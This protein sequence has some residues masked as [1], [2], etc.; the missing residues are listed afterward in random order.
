MQAQRRQMRPSKAN[1]IILTKNAIAPNLKHITKCMEFLSG[2]SDHDSF[3]NINKAN[4]WHE[5]KRKSVSLK[6][7]EEKQLELKTK[8]EELKQTENDL[9]EKEQCLN[10]KELDLKNRRKTMDIEQMR[11]KRNLQ[12]LA[13]DQ[14]LFERQKQ[15]QM[16]LI[17]LTAKK[18]TAYA[19]QLK[20]REKELLNR[21][22]SLLQREHA[23]YQR[24]KDVLHKEHKAKLM[25]KIC[26]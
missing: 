21:E 23:L 24:E 11:Y 5:N 1:E 16:A 12:Q 18:N 3:D 26:K 19:V 22:K 20:Q 13:D 2:Y 4:A 6:A 7:I 10:D 25:L 17:L 8:N 14:E 9:Y 15:Q